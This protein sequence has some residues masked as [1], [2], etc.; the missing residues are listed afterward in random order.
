MVKRNRKHHL[1]QRNNVWYFVATHR[2]TRY[3][4]RLS[5]NLKDSMELR[6]DYLY[7]LRHKGRLSINDPEQEQE[8]GGQLL[9]EVV[10]MWSKLML[11]KIKQQQIKEST[12]RDYRSIMNA[13]FL[14]RFGNIPIKDISAVDIE[15]Y[16]S[17]LECS[18]KRVNN[19]LVPMRNVFKMAKKRGYVDINI[20]QDV[21]NLRTTIPDV[22]PF[23]IGEINGFLDVAPSIY[24]P[25]FCVAFFT[26]MRF[27][28]MAALKWHNIDALKISFFKR[29]VNFCLLRLLLSDRYRGTW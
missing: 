21:D 7:E 27:G 17:E 14:P 3:H 23:T 6:D 12:L 10:K 16:T 9:G 28:E 20:M 2:G 4:Q 11:I 15:D 5:G 25:F 1:V 22:F 13:H 19:I 8:N 29:F 24:E 26:G 18:P